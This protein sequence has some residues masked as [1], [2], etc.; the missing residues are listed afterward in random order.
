MTTFYFKWN[1]LEYEVEIVQQSPKMES[2]HEDISRPHQ[3]EIQ[4]LDEVVNKVDN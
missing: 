2:D 1:S 3:S 4:V